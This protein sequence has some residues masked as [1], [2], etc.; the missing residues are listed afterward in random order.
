[1]LGIDMRAFLMKCL[2]LSIVNPLHVRIK[3]GRRQTWLNDKFGIRRSMLRYERGDG[4]P[5]YC[6]WHGAPGLLD[7]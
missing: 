1:M 3:T 5:I 6:W 7:G 4:N 2:R